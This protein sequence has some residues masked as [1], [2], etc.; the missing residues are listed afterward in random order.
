[1]I[2]VAT[3]GFEFSVRSLKA[4]YLPTDVDLFQDL[5]RDIMVRKRFEEA[6]A[7]ELQ[8]GWHHGT[9]KSSLEL[10]REEEVQAQREKEVTDLLN[11]PRVMEEGDV[12][13]VYVE[14]E[15]ETVFVEDGP[16]RRSTDIQEMLTRRFGHVSQATLAS[17]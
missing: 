12:V 10:L 16:L 15:V 7:M 14:T 17:T 4:A 8:A 11:K 9:K 5:E 1:M 6:S 3:I 13:K 2:L